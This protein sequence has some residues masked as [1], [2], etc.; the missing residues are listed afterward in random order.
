MHNLLIHSPPSPRLLQTLPPTIP[1]SMR[2]RHI[3]RPKIRKRAL[4]PQLRSSSE[5][6]LIRTLISSQIE[7]LSVPTWQNP[8]TRIHTQIQII[9]IPLFLRT[10]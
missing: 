8:G 4:I 5:V 1:T 10:G 9:F 6:I 2:L 7:R 3:P